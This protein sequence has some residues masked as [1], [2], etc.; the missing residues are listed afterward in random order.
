MY[1]ACE[2]QIV[3]S[4]LPGLLFTF[5]VLILKKYDCL[6]KIAHFFRLFDSYTS[7]PSDYLSY[8]SNYLLNR[9][10]T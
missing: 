6:A 1:W 8:S 3:G 9:E 10:T 4:N 5:T 2:Q 7:Y